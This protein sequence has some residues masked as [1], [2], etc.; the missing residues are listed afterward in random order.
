MN[1]F[2]IILLFCI[3]SV[4]ACQK[5]EIF[6]AE[7]DYQFT[8][9]SDG[10]YLP[11]LIKGNTASKV[12][13]ITLHG[14]PGDSGVQSFGYNNVFNQVED[15]FAMVYFDQRCAG[16]SQGNCDAKNLEVID[17][18]KDIDKLIDV[19]YEIY[20]EG[21]N[22]FLLGHSWGA[23]LGLSYLIDGE[24]KADIKGFIQSNGSHN[25]PKLSIEQRKFLRHYGHQQI[26]YNND[27]TEWSRIL[28]VVEK[29]DSNTLEGIIDVLA[30]TYKTV[31]LFEN[32][33]SI[34]S[35][36]LVV[37]NYA[38]QLSNSFLSTYNA[39]SNDNETFYTKLLNYDISDKLSEIS[40]PVGLF[41]GKFDAVHPPAMVHDIY[42]LLGTEEKELC[43]F[44]KSFHAPMAHENVLFQEKVI[45]FIK[46]YQ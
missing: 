2:K 45:E 17:F 22:L 30:E 21:I 13:C 19:L 29:S 34:L 32:V 14:G 20:G 18:V 37:S 43:F 23:S 38:L 35:P 41:W 7:A 8:L 39:S 12:F 15:E 33:D 24:N 31:K 27:V 4:I 1:N 11:V 42:E 44:N 16:I 26:A 25:I 3:L 36:S 9:S 40:N 28:D 5:E 10:A 6:I 46:R